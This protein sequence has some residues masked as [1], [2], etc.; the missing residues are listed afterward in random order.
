MADPSGV[1]NLQEL[2]HRRRKGDL[3]RAVEFTAAGVAS[4]VNVADH[5]L[6][7]TE[8]A[9]EIAV[10]HLHVIEIEEELYTI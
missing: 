9:D 3:L 5:V 2:P 6:A 10:H 1:A 4:R 8:P 7:L